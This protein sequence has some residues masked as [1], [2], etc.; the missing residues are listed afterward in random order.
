MRCDPIC[1]FRR[2]DFFID[3][4]LRNANG[5]VQ[6]GWGDDKYVKLCMWLIGNGFVDVNVNVSEPGVATIAIPLASEGRRGR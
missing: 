2:A 3:Y 4:G 6:Q 5:I 1:A